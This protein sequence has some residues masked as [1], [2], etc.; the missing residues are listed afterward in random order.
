ML[1]WKSWFNMKVFFIQDILNADGNFLTFEEFRNKFSIKTN[2]LRYFQLM[3]AITSDLKKKAMLAEVP[4][5][6]QLLNS[7]TVSLTPESTPVDLANMH[8]KHH[9]KVL[10]KNSTVEPTASKPGKSTLPR[11]IQN[12]KTNFHLYIIE[13]EI[14]Y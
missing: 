5:H 12:G 2:Y 10:N 14:I 4:S 11:N 13:Q 6:E 8:C 1:F 3:A 7:T 9:Y